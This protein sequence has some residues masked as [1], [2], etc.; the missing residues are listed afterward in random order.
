MQTKKIEIKG[1]KDGL[2]IK[3]DSGEWDKQERVLLDQ[4]KKQSEFLA[5]GRLAL[6]VGNHI[7]K[8]AQL[9]ALRDAI[10]DQGVKLWAVLS[11]SPTTE[12][13]AQDLGLTIKIQKPL[14]SRVRTKPT[15]AAI[16]GENALFIR[17]TLRSGQKVKHPGHIIVLGDVNPGAEIIAGGSIIVWGRLRGVVHAG[18]QGDADTVVCAL[19]LSPTQLR[20]A[21]RISV[22]PPGGKEAQPE[23][24]RLEKGQVVAH[25]WK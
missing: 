15:S 24:A 12:K 22:S 21:D 25:P 17:R 4:I 5:G 16:Q 13:A 3:L 18:A 1:I 8:A 19:N 7:L 20:I 14:P 2:L 10:S 23:I 9:G 11:N 6:D